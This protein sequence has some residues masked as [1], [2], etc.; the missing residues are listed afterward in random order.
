MITHRLNLYFCIQF[1]ENPACT[2]NNNMDKV[3]TSPI[4]IFFVFTISSLFISS[5]PAHKHKS[6]GS[7]GG[8][9]KVSAESPPDRI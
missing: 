3:W 6:G 1:Q 5:G 7:D 4:Y 9:Q 2:K 8:K